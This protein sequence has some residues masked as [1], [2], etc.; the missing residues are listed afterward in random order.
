MCFRVDSTKIC[1][2]H[3]I[4]API[5]AYDARR[6]FEIVLLGEWL[7]FPMRVQNI[8]VNGIVYEKLARL[9]VQR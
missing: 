8:L 9:R 5:T 2:R 1:K 4:R 7:F 3:R 6:S